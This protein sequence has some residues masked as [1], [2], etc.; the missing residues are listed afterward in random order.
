MFGTPESLR[1]LANSANWFMEGTFTSCPPQF[2]QL[3]TIHGLGGGRNVVGAYALLPNKTRATYSEFLAEIQRMTNNSVPHSVLFDFETSMLGAV[4]QMYRKH[5]EL[6]VC[7]PY[8]RM[9]INM[10]RILA[11]DKRI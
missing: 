11:C 8:R 9:Y 1:F 10:Y 6:G 3:H 2:T 5:Q 4:E 7:F